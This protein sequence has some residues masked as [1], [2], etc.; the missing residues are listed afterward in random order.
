MR[1]TTVIALAAAAAAPALA[2]PVALD[3]RSNGKWG[4][5]IENVANAADAA[6][7]AVNIGTSIYG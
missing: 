1:S 4:H 2:A 6:S 7:S 5:I 3:A